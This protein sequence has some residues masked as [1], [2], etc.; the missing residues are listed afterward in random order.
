MKKL[1]IF[2]MTVLV[3]LSCSTSK[4]M[5]DGDYG[6][7]KLKQEL[8]DDNTFRITQYSQDDTYGYMEKNPILV[9]GKSDGPKN[10]R[11]FLNAL[12]GPIL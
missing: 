1:L 3:L 7:P 6:S 11:R 9:G 12:S 8:I 10:E 2:T 4:K 5:T